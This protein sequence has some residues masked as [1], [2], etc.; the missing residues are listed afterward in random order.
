M[1]R[2]T[3]CFPRTLIG[4]TLSYLDLK[5]THRQLRPVYKGSNGV[6]AQPGNQS[7]EVSNKR[8]N[9]SIIVRCPIMCSNVPLAM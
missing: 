2:A 7:K 6:V 3:E 8:G 4:R 1:S 5:F 9:H